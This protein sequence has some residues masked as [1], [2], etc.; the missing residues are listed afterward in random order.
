MPHWSYGLCNMLPS[1]AFAAEPCTI[2][3]HYSKGSLRTGMTLLQLEPA[4][5]QT[6]APLKLHNDYSLIV[7]LLSAIIDKFE[8]IVTHFQRKAI[9]ILEVSHAIVTILVIGRLH[10]NDMKVVCYVTKSLSS[11]THGS[12]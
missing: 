7:L 5:S 4:Q 11:S 8:K 2:D 6:D 3:S 1:V 9:K 12:A 10:N